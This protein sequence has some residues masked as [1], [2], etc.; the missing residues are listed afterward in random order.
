MSHRAI[1]RGGHYNSRNLP[2]SHEVALSRISELELAVQ[3]IETQLEF[4]DPDEFDTDEAYLGWKKRSTSALAH[5][6]N[7]LHFLRR[8]IRGGRPPSS[9]DE[10]YRAALESITSSV[11]RMTDLMKDAYKRVYT[12]GHLPSDLATAH[13]RSSQIVPLI[14]RCNGLF[15]DLKKQ[16]EEG[17]VGDDTM[18]KLRRPLSTLYMEMVAERKL[19]GEF[20]R[21]QRGE[22]V[23]WTLFLISL[24]ERGMEAQL[25]L[26]E[27]ETAILEEIRDAKL[28]QMSPPVEPAI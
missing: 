18:V 19:L 8:W 22:R 4:G 5:Y 6:R 7:E 21:S 27:E 16:A 17:K 3:S 15:A 13:K 12:E 25:V 26:A 28:A 2:P 10:H 14:Q 23:D 24:V 1:A 11:R 9:S 20:M